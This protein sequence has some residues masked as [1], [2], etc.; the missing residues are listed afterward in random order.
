MRV[1]TATGSGGRMIKDKSYYMTELKQR[2]ATL[3]SELNRLNA[4]H[5]T[6]LKENANTVA[7]EKK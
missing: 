3:S 4:E 2:V 6:S 5:E 7:F 1:A